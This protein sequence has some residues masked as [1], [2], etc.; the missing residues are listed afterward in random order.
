MNASWS[1]EQ[2][3]QF[4]KQAKARVGD[5]GWRYLSADQRKALVAHEVCMVLIGQSDERFTGIQ[6]L[7]RDTFQAAG[8]G[9]EQES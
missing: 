9:P 6:K 4:A 1:A 8:V 2:A 5:A 3:K 7:I